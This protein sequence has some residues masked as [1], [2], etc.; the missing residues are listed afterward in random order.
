MVTADVTTR[1]R[2]QKISNYTALK[3]IGLNKWQII[4]KDFGRFLLN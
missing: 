4:K 1:I 2:T 3:G